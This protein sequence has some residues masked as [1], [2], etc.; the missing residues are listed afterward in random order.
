MKITDEDMEPMFTF[1]DVEEILCNVLRIA[2]EKRS[3]FRSRVQ[4]LQKMALPWGTNVGRGTRVIYSLQQIAE[5]VLYFELLDAGLTPALIATHFADAPWFKNDANFRDAVEAIGDPHGNDP[6]IVLAITT[7][8]LRHLRATNAGSDMPS[9]GDLKV[10]VLRSATPTIFDP[11]S[12]TPRPF[13]LVFASRRIFEIM[14]M[15][16]LTSSSAAENDHGQMRARHSGLRVSSKLRKF[17]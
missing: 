11:R 7:N 3:S 10:N 5:L 6:G 15:V 1:K 14:E 12:P 17:D 9:S 13:V 16:G 8:A 4:Q 2:N